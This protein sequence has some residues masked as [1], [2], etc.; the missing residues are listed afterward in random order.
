[1][2]PPALR[3]VEGGCI[4]RQGAGDLDALHPDTVDP[5]GLDKEIRTRIK[6]AGKQGQHNDLEIAHTEQP[7]LHRSQPPS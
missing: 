4:E 7:G 1:M 6:N 3:K 5:E 2:A